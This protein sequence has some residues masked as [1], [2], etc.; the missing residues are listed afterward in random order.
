MTCNNFD[1]RG[2]RAAF[3]LGIGRGSKEINYSAS[4]EWFSNIFA[5]LKIFHQGDNKYVN[6]PTPKHPYKN[7]FVWVTSPISRAPLEK[8]LA[9]AGSASGLRTCEKMESGLAK[10]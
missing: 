10:D 6:S 3:C 7:Q 4:F 5:D 1:A 9:H 8:A 2:P